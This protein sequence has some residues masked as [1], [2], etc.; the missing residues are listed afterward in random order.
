MGSTVLIVEVFGM[1]TQNVNLPD[2]QSQF[3]RERVKAA[4]EREREVERAGCAHS[5]SAG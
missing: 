1:P 5:N 2:H 4:A 3:I